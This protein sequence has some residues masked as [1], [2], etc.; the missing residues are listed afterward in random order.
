MKKPVFDIWHVAIPVR[1]LS[2]S[3]QFYCDQLGFTLFGLDEQSSKKQAFIQSGKSEFTI[4]LFE[5]KDPAYSPQRPDHLAFECENIVQYRDWLLKNG[6]PDIPEILE[7]DNGVKYLPLRDPDG[8]A[9]EF[10]QGRK[11]YEDS[12][13]R[14]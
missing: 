1:Q 14:L 12:I 6:L 8:V 7:F 10:F 2:S 11:I 3:V 5:P 4:E 13:A 9:L